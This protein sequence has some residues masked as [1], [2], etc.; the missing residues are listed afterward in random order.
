VRLNEELAQEAPKE[1][2]YKHNLAAA[3]HDLAEFAQQHNTPADARRIM[4][5][6]LRQ[7]RAAVE[8]A[9]KQ[10]VFRT[11]LCAYYLK[12]VDLLSEQDEYSAAAK[13][14]GELAQ[15]AAENWAELHKAAIALGRCMQL[16]AKDTKLP[17]A[18][19]AKAIQTYGDQ[20]MALLRRAVNHG[21]KESTLLKQAPEF[22]ELR[23]R[24]DFKK[25]VAD[26]EGKA[27]GRSP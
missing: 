26:V 13:A 25:L 1:P 20:A 22:A 27:N 16:A 8:L 6:A 11:T 7:Q 9:P 4:E 15:I 18:E 17:P 14:I 23:K 24:D 2:A 12:L 5:D 19:R 10:A 3:L 21:F